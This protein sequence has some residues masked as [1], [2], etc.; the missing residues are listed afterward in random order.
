MSEKFGI[1]IVGTGA[2][3]K[4]HYIATNSLEGVEVVAACDIDRARL[5]E[6]TNKHS[7]EN[8]YTDLGKMLKN[9]AVR[10]ILVCTPPPS[11]CSIAEQAAA[12]GVHV[13][14]E[15]PLTLDL[16][17]ADHSIVVC[18]EA[19]VKYAMISQR[20]FFD[21]AQRVKKVIDDGKLGKV[22]L[23]DCII[24][25]WR[26]KEYYEQEPWRGTWD[27]EGG[28]CLIN[29]S[30][31][32]IDL[33]Q[34]FMGP[35]D[36]VYGM[37][38]NYSH[39]YIEAEDTAVAA[40]RFKSGAMGIILAT[41]I[42]NPTFGAKITIHGDSGASVSFSE[43]PEGSIGVNEIWSIPGEEGLA[44][45]FKNTGPEKAYPGYHALQ[46]REFVHAILED[47]PPLVTA[48]EGLKPL[49]IVK[50]IYKSNE[51]GQP[52]KMPMDRNL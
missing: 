20:R 46:I 43:T 14:V 22:V 15:K 41:L 16:K 32:A 52:I 1:G 40:L 12:N 10:A 25:W 37:W 47:R 38:D 42:T 39:Q 4:T 18:K 2:I 8:A 30:M 33:Y 13:M 51:I 5:D 50:A 9:P 7:V 36:T 24:K 31:H 34:W 48:E 19:G 44:E 28:A 45:N 49:E 3:A 26:Q 23:G 35:V 29:Q 21:A 11:H 6:F 27:K 17:Q